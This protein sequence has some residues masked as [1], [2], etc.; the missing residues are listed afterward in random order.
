[1][2]LAVLLGLDP[3]WAQ[4]SPTAAE[5]DARQL[6]EAGANLYDQGQYA[7]ALEAWQEAYRLSGREILL[8]DIAD[9]YERLG[10]LELA[11]ATFKAYR[12]V[13]PPEEQDV[14]TQRI[15]SLEARLAAQRAPPQPVVTPPVVP[16][17]A[18]RPAPQPGNVALWAGLGVGAAGL[19]SGVTFGSLALGTKSAADCGDDGGAWLCSTAGRQSYQRAPTWALVADLSFGVAA[20]S[21]A[22]GVGVW[23]A[24]RRGG[25]DVAVGPSGA[26]VR[27]AF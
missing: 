12:G 1:M 17:P 26:A 11:I 8:Y 20:V 2:I 14:L 6:Y 16:P 3:A 7:Y 13:A 24:R 10:D 19:A 4:E 23:A 15:R 27:V 18:V 22:V 9:C 21:T 5:D 25:V